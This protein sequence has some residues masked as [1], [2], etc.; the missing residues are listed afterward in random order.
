MD[1]WFTIGFIATLTALIAFVWSLTN[2]TYAALEAQNGN[3]R[4]LKNTSQ[5]LILSMGLG[6]G[7]IGGIFLSDLMSTKKGKQTLFSNANTEIATAATSNS[8]STAVATTIGMPLATTGAFPPSVLAGSAPAIVSGSAIF[9]ANCAACHRADGG[10][11]IGPNFTDAYFIHGNS[12]GD[13]VNI[14]NNG[15]P[16]K[17]M[18]AWK[19]Q[20][21]AAEIQAVAQYIS[22][23][24]GKNVAGGKAPEGKFYGKTPSVNPSVAV[25]NPS[26]AAPTTTNAGG[27][28]DT[29]KA[30]PDAPTVAA[31]TATAPTNAPVTA[32]V[33]TPVAALLSASDLPS[34]NTNSGKML[35]NSILGCAHCHGINAVGH[36]DKRNIRE[37][38]KREGGADKA[39]EV[40]FKTIQIG[41][42]GTA[43]PSWAH[44][45]KK[46][47][48]DVRTFLKSIQED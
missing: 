32:A 24:E 26:A 29:N 46:Q 47:I 3:T 12:V 19:E 38:Y 11:M 40:F 23:L 28:T 22:S 41:R 6:I 7:A 2:K 1:K 17:A 25:L 34:G 44:L 15:V 42:P 43:M 33:E 45:T 5:W 14:I 48:A 16:G 36:T 20:L 8:S 18:A 37:L 4:Y 27:V 13:M 31:V 35:F 30:Q 9:Q 10:G 21:T 39:D